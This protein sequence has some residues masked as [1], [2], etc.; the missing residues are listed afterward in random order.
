MRAEVR[1]FEWPDLDE[2]G[3]SEFTLMVFTAGTVGGQGGDLF[4]IEVCTPE[5]LADLIRRDGIVS[6][7]HRLF[8]EH[9]DTARVE[10]W[11]QDRLRRIDGET[12]TEVAEKIARL[13]FWEFED[14]RE[15]H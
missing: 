14:Y 11:V 9:I 5:G 10:A 3:S 6:G 1:S 12:W 7:R 2:P 15:T 8:M 13:G 4:Q